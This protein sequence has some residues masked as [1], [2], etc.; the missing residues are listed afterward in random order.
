MISVCMITYNGEK[1]VLAQV[2]S[3]LSQLG[4][5][6]ELVISDDGS[7]DRTLQIL[8]GMK[9]DRIRLLTGKR[10]GNPTFNMENALANARG[11]VIIMSDQDDVWVENKVDIIKK[12]LIDFDYI[13]SDCYITDGNLNVIYNTRYIPEA[14]I[15]I[16][17]YAAL[18]KPTPYQGSC[19]AFNR[20]VLD[21]ALPFPPYIQSHDRWIGYIGSFFFKYALIPEKLIFYRRH[22]NNA[23]TSSTGKST[24]SFLQK[25]GYRFG[26]ITALI[27]RSLRNG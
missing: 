5:D 1:Y 13:V 21:K 27:K 7:S 15:A 4:K 22:G 11:D 10:F 2:T 9:D 24:N 19:A 8:E 20:K 3:I 12:Y 16:N 6:D 17:K 23:S 25:L 14:G 26:Y 18:F